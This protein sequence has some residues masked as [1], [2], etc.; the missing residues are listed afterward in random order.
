MERVSI[1]K[2][3]ILWVWQ[4]RKGL[5]IYLNGETLKQRDSFLY[6]D[7]AICGDRN[8]DTKLGRRIS[9]AANVIRDRRISRKCKGEVITSCVTRHTS[10]A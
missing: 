6:L 9:A 7:G 8:L 1:E 5:E 3:E 2:T 10:M 4:R